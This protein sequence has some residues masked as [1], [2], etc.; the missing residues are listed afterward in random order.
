MLIVGFVVTSYS[1]FPYVDTSA[2][3]LF[4]FKTTLAVLVEGVSLDEG[5]VDGDEDVAGVACIYCDKSTVTETKQIKG[6]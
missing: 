4:T 1:L 5:D 3:S 6:G 2:P